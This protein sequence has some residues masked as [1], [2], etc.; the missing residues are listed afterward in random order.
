MAHDQ[1]SILAGVI[2]KLT[3]SQG[4]G[5]FYES[6]GGRIYRT[7]AP[8]DKAEALAVVSVVEDEPDRYFDG[9]DTFA[10]LQISVF[11]ARGSSETT[12]QAIT[13]KLLDLLDG[14]ALTITGHGGGQ[15]WAENRG[16]PV[17]EDHRIQIVTIWGIAATAA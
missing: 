6:V 4:S 1:E 3:A 8:P 12:V 15:A 2:A 14:A 7:I 16:I 11:G 17:H 9:C 13:K 5:T 10:T